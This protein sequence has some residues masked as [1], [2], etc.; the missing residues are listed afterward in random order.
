MESPDRV[1]MTELVRDGMNELVIDVVNTLVWSV[2]D[3]VSSYVQIKPTGLTARPVIEY[4][5]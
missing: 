2:K 1:D 4:Y 3:P 5:G